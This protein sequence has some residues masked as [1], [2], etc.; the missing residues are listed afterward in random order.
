MPEV[1][2]REQLTSRGG[3]GPAYKLTQERRNI[4]AWSIREKQHSG[5]VGKFWPR[6]D[7]PGIGEAVSPDR[8]KVLKA[9][10]VLPVGYILDLSLLVVRSL[11]NFTGGLGLV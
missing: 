1:Q 2:G 9:T 8:L 7:A 11:L 3:A 6:E 10:S 5:R 4:P